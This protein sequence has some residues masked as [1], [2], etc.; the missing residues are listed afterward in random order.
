LFI[1]LLDAEHAPRISPTIASK[2]NFLIVFI[3]V[4]IRFLFVVQFHC[5]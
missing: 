3:S 4:I 1:T 2:L 5:F